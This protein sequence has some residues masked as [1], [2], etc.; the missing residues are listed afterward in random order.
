MES[1]NGASQLGSESG[2][3]GPVHYREWLDLVEGK[4][5]AVGGKRPDAVFLSQVSRSPVVRASTK[6]G[7]YELDPAAPQRLR[8]ELQRLQQELRAVVSNV[9]TQAADIAA[10]SQRQQE[11]VLE[12]ARHQRALE[13]AL[14][15]LGSAVD[16][17]TALA[18]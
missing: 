15:V 6:A 1:P 14:R 5:Y 2:K 4:G 9:P 11:L 12:I 8:H 10:G 18:A 16:T 13:E 17:P 3:R 7:L